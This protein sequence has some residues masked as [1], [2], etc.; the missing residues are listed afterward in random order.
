MILL[1]GPNTLKRRSSEE[2][3]EYWWELAVFLGGKCDPETRQLPPLYA[4]A[5][6]AVR[7]EFALRG[8][9]LSLF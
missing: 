8:V 5:Y 6:E 7:A 1:V 9:Q 4:S 3:N 2:L